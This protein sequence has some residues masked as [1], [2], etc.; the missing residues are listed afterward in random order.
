[1]VNGYNIMIKGLDNLIQKIYKNKLLEVDQD[2]E[3]IIKA[4]T[5]FYMKRLKNQT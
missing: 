3:E 4:H 5:Y 1:M 2:G